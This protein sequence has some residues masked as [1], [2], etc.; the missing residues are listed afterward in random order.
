MKQLNNALNHLPRATNAFTC[1]WYFTINF[2]CLGIILASLLNWPS[3]FSYAGIAFGT[4]MIL[5]V[6]IM[7][8]FSSPFTLNDSC[9]APDNDSRY[10]N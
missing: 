9:E 8:D 6:L 1:K 2:L 7:R 10:S 3:Q 5:V 4:C